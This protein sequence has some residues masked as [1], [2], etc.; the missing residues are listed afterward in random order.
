[1]HKVGIDCRKEKEQKLF[2]WT[3]ITQQPGYHLDG[4]FLFF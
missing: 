2:L 4:Y 1:M 3:V